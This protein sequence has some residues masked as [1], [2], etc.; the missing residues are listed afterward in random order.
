MSHELTRVKPHTPT[1]YLMMPYQSMAL[2][3]MNSVGG[4]GGNCKDSGCALACTPCFRVPPPCAEGKPKAVQ[5]GTTDPHP[6]SCA[7]PH[8]YVSYSHPFLFP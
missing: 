1:S 8:Q 4:V 7:L 5:R 2:T 6:T 3:M